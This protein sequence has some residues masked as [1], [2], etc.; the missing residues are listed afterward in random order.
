MADQTIDELNI[1]INAEAKQSSSGLDKLVSSIER[2][3]SAT[4]GGVGQLTGIAA[5]ISKLSAGLSGMKSQ[6]GIV[7]SLAN[8]IQKLNDAKTDRISGSISTLT[9]SLKTLGGMD[10]TVKTLVNDL[11]ALARSGGGSMLSNLMIS[12]EALAA[13]NK[14]VID[15]SALKSAKAQD[16][17]QA[18]ADKNKAIE[19]SARAAA[20]Q[21]QQLTDSINTAIQEHITQYGSAG[22]FSN[23]TATGLESVLPDYG[24]ETSTWPKNASSE[25]NAASINSLKAAMG[26]VG[27][28]AENAMNEVSTGSSRAASFMDKLK[29]SVSDA[30]DKLSSLGNTSNSFFSMGRFYGWYF[31][32]RQIASVFGGFI[33]NINSYIENVNLFDVAMGSA[34]QSGEKLANSLQSVLGVD[35]GEAVRYMGVFQELGS[36]FGIANKQAVTM[37][38]NMTQLGYDL[39]SFYN[40]STGTAFEKLES[41]YTGQSRAARSL[42]IDI[43]NARLQQELYNLGIKEKVNDLTQAD[44]AELRYIA[45]M[46]QTTNAQGDMARTIQTPANALRVLQAQLTITG[47]AIGSIFIP[48]LEAIL[49]VVTAVIEVI[50]DLA[51]ELASLFGFKMPKIDYSSLK[52]IS[53]SA[54]DA[55]T[56]VSGIGDNAQKSKKQLDNLISGF[57]ELNII[58]TSNDEDQNGSGAGNNGNILSG[59]DLP[60]YDAL[61]DAVGNNIDAIKAKLEQYKPLI[62]EILKDVLAVGAALLTWKLT[63]GFF[64]GLMNLL[65]GLKQFKGQFVE[66]AAG[67]ALAAGLFTFAYTH[68]ETFRK[69]LAV[70]GQG[71]Q[72]IGKTI[73]DFASGAAKSLGIKE[74]SGEFWTSTAAF[75]VAAIGIVAIALGAPIFGTI[76][77]IAG[78]SVLAIQAIGYAASDSIEPVNLFGE[79]ISN[80]TE[81]KLKPFIQECDTLDETIKSLKWGGQIITDK[82]VSNVKSQVKT[83]ADT[84]IN[85]LDAD[86][87]TALKNLNP[88][89]NMLDSK[90]Y[91]SIIQASGKYYDQQKTTVQQ[92]EDEINTIMQKAK[93]Q[94][95]T[96][97]QGESDEILKIKSNME[98]TGIKNLTQS[99]TE[100][101]L[102]FQSLKDNHSALSAQEAAAIVQNSAKQRD[103]TIGDANKQYDGIMTEAQRMYDVGAINKD[104]YDKIAQAAG[105]SKDDTIKQATEQHTKIVDEAKKQAGEYVDQVDWQSGQVKSKWQVMCDT[106]KNT[107]VTKWNEIKNFFLQALP[108][109]W[110][111]NVAPWFT[112]AKWQGLFNEVKV[113]AANKW[114]EIKDWWNNTAIVKWWKED[115]APWFTA[116]KWQDMMDGVKEGFKSTFKNAVNSAIEIFNNFI[117]WVNDRMHFEW[118][119][120]RI[121]GKLVV[122]GGSVQLFTIPT[123]PKLATGDVAY[124][125]KI[126]EY[127]EYP[128]ASSNPEVVAPQSIIRETVTEGNEGLAKAIIVAAERIVEAINEKDTTVKLNDK[129]L[130]KSTNK[131]NANKGFNLGLQPS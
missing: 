125:P 27:S 19:D 114:Q 41:V 29:Q 11:G 110:N 1:K 104:Q 51:S 39:A 38:E 43:S 14:A 100:S 68:S 96:L 36:S 55:S 121:M 61:A 95:R 126:A 18:I 48:A 60:Q 47:R 103:T 25:I 119:D 13:K 66:I 26:E 83:I 17:L 54:D 40:I 73:A 116:K 124:R 82:D 8:S 79:G 84:L 3:K 106:V 87:N 9:A 33:N 123:I 77:V 97:T 5:S 45:I 115:V 4:G 56:A 7:S 49:P 101:N 16:G 74:L 20:Q 113:A 128:G 57:D 59:I 102:I 31:I 89:K 120:I 105:K 58:Q 63:T 75:V 86:K 88:L 111:T 46:K 129:V 64:N 67:L 93:D 99:Q 35:S 108:N 92:G 76:A 30:K 52:D 112:A 80:T 91:D 109:W 44:K 72:E 130:A 69:G 85:G 50:G 90:T 122:K 81:K 62:E 94:H 6:S 28:S 98:T 42:G 21:E 118:D 78:V 23:K 70:L 22:G 34:A 10:P 32:L 65:P 131:V 127:G 15:Q 107:A 2:L 53:T 24:T 71:F 117:R 37:S 12:P